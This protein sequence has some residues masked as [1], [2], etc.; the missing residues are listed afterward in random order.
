[1]SADE[2]ASLLKEEVMRTVIY[3]PLYWK[4]IQEQS[5][6]SGASIVNLLSL[7]QAGLQKERQN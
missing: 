7:D 2:L 1:M 3:L 6:D 4:L 5:H